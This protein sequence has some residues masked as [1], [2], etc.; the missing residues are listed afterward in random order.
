MN[1]RSTTFYIILIAAIA[2]TASW[3]YFSNRSKQKAAEK[4]A[5]TTEVVSNLT[6]LDATDF[7]P[8]VKNE[9]KLASDKALE[10]NPG[11]LLSAIEIEI[12][13]DLSPGSVTSRYVFTRSS[14][15]DNNWI[16]LVRQP[17]QNFLRSLVPTSDYLGKVTP[18]NTTLWKYNYVTA[19][20]IA[21]KSG[22]LEWRESNEL[23]KVKL[24][25]KNGGTN[26]W[27]LWAIVYSSKDS[28]FSI[29]LDA[30]SGKPTE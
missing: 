2:I 12:G 4:Q 27:L 15:T 19:L 3:T 14:D 9:Y 23:T 30:N 11:Y 7:D 17:S 13:K 20:Q 28:E 18:I 24:T 5:A 8:V 1:F 25:L 22:G 21:E 16:I 29:R 10:A 26:N 6:N